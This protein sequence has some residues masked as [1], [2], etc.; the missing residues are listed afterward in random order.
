MTVDFRE[1]GVI[2]PD[3]WQST[4]LHITS[5]IV[6]LFLVVSYSTSIPLVKPKYRLL[7]HLYTE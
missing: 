6:F 3:F 1:Q 4:V 7:C 2:K 5:C